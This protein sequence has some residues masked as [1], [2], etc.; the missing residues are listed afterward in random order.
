M[1]GLEYL[2]YITMF[3]AFFPLPAYLYV[4]V[5]LAFVQFLFIVYYIATHEITLKQL[6]NKYSMFLVTLLAYAAL[7]ALWVRDISGW[8]IYSAVLF[9]TIVNSFNLWIS[10]TNRRILSNLL[11][12]TI[13]A[14]LV[15]NL[16]GWFEVITGIY[17]FAFNI[18][19]I[20][21]NRLLRRPITFF[22]NVNDYATFLLFSLIFLVSYQPKGTF[23][24]K[25]PFMLKKVGRWLLALSTFGLIIMVGSRGILLVAVLS[26]SFLILFKLKDNFFK[27]KILLVGVGF[28]TLSALVLLSTIGIPPVESLPEEDLT[29]VHLIYNGL[30]Y[31]K[32]T[33]FV[34]VGP[35]NVSYYLEAHRYFPVGHIR[36]IHNW[37]IEFLV[38]YGIVFFVFYIFLYIKNIVVSFKKYYYTRD[39]IYVFTTAWALAF[40]VGSVISSSLFTTIWVMFIHNLMFIVVD[41]YKVNKNIR[42][43]AYEEY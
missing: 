26:V 6:M 13:V 31:L 41:R 20:P 18:D 33:L 37:W 3:T 40:I 32:D 35:G 36:T 29:R 17:P 14:I 19:N 11:K 43:T 12:L 21:Y 42:S 9:V 27:K 1:K 24:A 7:G 4:Q 5:L 8:A 30:H 16:V 34:G 39:F 25:V 10:L 15:Q 28:V 23:Y 38:M 2:L 22:K